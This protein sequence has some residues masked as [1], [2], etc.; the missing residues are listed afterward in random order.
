VITVV[1]RKTH[2]GPGLKVFRPHLL[3]NPYRVG[4]HGSRAECIAQFRRWLWAQLQVPAEVSQHMRRL[5][6]L[7]RGGKDIT[8]ICC[9]APEP[10]HSEVIKSAIE[11]MAGSL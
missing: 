9:C 7:H 3:G 11:W 5:A 10:C 8:L 1:N 2:R 6:E 4:V